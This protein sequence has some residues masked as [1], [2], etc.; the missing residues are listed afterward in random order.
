M[1]KLVLGILAHVDAGKTTL[2][3]SMLYISGKIRKL[4]RVDNKDAYLDTYELEKARGI[5][6]FSKQ[7][8]FNWEDVQITLLDT[9]GHVDFCA[10]MERTLQVLDYGIIVISGVEGIQGHTLTLWRLLD[11]YQVPVFIFINKMDQEGADRE[12]ILA[13][14][15][16]HLGEGCIAF[17]V[18][19]EQDFYEQLAVCDDYLMEQYFEAGM[20]SEEE[21][22]RAISKRKVFPCFFG[23]AL[24]LVGVESFL[25]GIIHY[26]HEKIYP[27]DFGARVF[28]ISRDEQ[29]NRLTHLKITG[30]TL[31]VRS[32]LTNKPVENIVDDEMA[33]TLWE[34]KINQIRCYS[35]TKYEVIQEV[36]AGTICAV[37]GL[38]HTYP[39]QGLGVTM[40]SNHTLLEPILSYQMILPDECNP[41]LLL[42]KLK[43]LEEEEPELHIIW[44]EALQ[45]IHV[46]L[47]G[48]VQI[49]ILQQLI[50]ERFGVSV[51]FGAGSILYKESIEN[52]V[53]GVGHFEPLR[54]Y[55]EVHLLL[56]P[57]P[58][59]SGLQLATCCSEDLLEKNWQ[60]LIISHLK[61]KSYKGVLI[62]APIT[63]M[64][65]TLVAG[66]AH[67]KHTEGGDFR[68]ATYRAVRQGLMQA[69]SYL[70]EPYYTF[71]LEIPTGSVGRA[72]H[73][74]EKMSGSYELTHKDKDWVVLTGSAPVAT[75]CNYQKEVMAYTKG[76]GK[77]CCHVKGY[78]RCHNEIE[79][80]NYNNYDAE[81]DVSDTPDSIFCEHGS[82]FTVKWDEVF[83]HMHIQNYLST[84]KENPFEK[85]NTVTT[86]SSEEQWIGVDEIDQ[87]INRTFFANQG[88]KSAWKKRK[89]AR[90]SYYEGT[91]YTSLD[92]GAIKEE[93][94]LVDGY[95][96]I[97]AWPELK[98]IAINNMDGAKIK[99]LETLCNYQGIK[100]CKIIVVFDAYKVKGHQTEITS[101]HNIHVVYT[102]EAE[103]ADRYI[104]RFAHLHHKDYR[105]TVA[106]SDGLEQVIIRGKGC[107]L[108]SARELKQELEHAQQQIMET[109][110]CTLIKEKEH[111]SEVLDDTLKQQMQDF[112]QEEE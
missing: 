4:G 108:L 91:K 18:P 93:Y 55:A 38:N 39:G 50:L 107:G 98:E 111:L 17:D 59:G 62:G 80:I 12:K 63:D 43:Q 61:E 67:K 40:G 29:G 41:R 69:K 71:E 33:S 19:K 74:I 23:S 76:L 81:R 52:I 16:Q 31:S 7:A 101:Y 84:H 28:K 100:G 73:D 47:M 103:T 92:Q 90:E 57:A 105:V 95:N 96:I 49:E 75:M 34:E 112:I 110:S 13:N 60:R 22:R 68:E 89:S 6:I 82:G 77:L 26:T 20:I 15:K 37:T 44:H 85:E 104:E 9:P 102:K 70:L 58:I 54:H 106:T 42:P 10:E 109:Y 83:K 87:I 94:L 3:E 36:G 25:Q 78:N 1:R 27:E 24:K 11:S 48:E 51:T 66:R 56:E 32:T 35:G 64:K 65:I 30:G 72:M 2:S 46:Q 99:L 45:E 5:T 21:V 14:L 97:F 8:I 79:I 53:E 86:S 88:E